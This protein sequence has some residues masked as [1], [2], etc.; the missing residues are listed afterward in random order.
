MLIYASFPTDLILGH[1]EETV[2][3]VDSVDSYSK[4]QTVCSK[5][6]QYDDILYN[7]I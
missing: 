7:K 2:K 4:S 3:V 5:Y 1:I 6:I